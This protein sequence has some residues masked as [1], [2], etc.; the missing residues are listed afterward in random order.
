MKQLLIPILISSLLLA[1]CGDPGADHA[2]H[3]MDHSKA[4]VPAPPVDPISVVNG[5]T[6]VEMT[7]NDRMKYNLETFTVP[8]GSPVKL[9]FSNVGKMPKT[10]MGHN[11][12]FLAPTADEKAFVTAAA[13]SRD[14]GYIPVSMKDQVLFATKM[15]GPGET[16][17][18][19]YSAPSEPGEYVFLCTFPAHMYAGMRG[20]MIVE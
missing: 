16:D 9:L 18:V 6:I 14:S 10:S 8:A 17:T 11:V 4:A 1:G 7:G 15:L 13:S 19:E 12:V 20:V 5:V 2:H 3:G